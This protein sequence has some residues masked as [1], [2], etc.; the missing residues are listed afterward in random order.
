MY[1]LWFILRQSRVGTGREEHHDE[2]DLAPWSSFALHV[3]RLQHP[4]RARGCVQRSRRPDP[5]RARVPDIPGPAATRDAEAG[6]WALWNPADSC[7]RRCTRSKSTIAAPGP[8]S[9]DEG[10]HAAARAVG[11]T[12]EDLHVGEG[13]RQLIVPTAL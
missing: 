8:Q 7:C 13:D 1:Y 12:R 6:S 5:Q 9:V 4:R 3:Q 2:K 10:S 11:P